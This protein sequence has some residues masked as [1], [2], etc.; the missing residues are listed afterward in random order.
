ME[1]N[2]LIPVQNLVP[3]DVFK[4]GGTDPIINAI[5]AEVEKFQPDISTAKSRNE[6]ASIAHKVARSK[7]FIDNMG[8]AVKDKYQSIIKPIDAE[9]KKVRD[10]LDA[11]KEQVRKPLTDWE[12]EQARIKAEEEALEKYNSDWDQAIIDNDIFN[13]ERELKRREEELARQEADRKAKEEADRIESERIA[14]EEQ[15][16]KDAAEQAKRDA[17]EAA[18]KR[19]EEAIRKQLEAEQAAKKAQ[20]EKEAAELRAKIEAEE[21]EKKRLADIQAAKEQA[22]RDKQE[23]LDRQRREQEEKERAEQERLRKIQEEEDRRKA[24]IEHRG[25]INRGILHALV[26]RFGLSSQTA[27]S[28]IEAIAKGEIENISINY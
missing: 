3:E 1:E 10:E 12:N 11:L 14:H 23:A 20:E 18:R 19:E 13:R 15:L 28:I 8:K 22:E 7:T 16:K 27:K 2:M 9:R 24:D 5:K 25:S 4:E 21:A 6:I 26:T 17:E